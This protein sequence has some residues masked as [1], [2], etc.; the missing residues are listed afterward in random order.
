MSTRT[1]VRRKVSARRDA[2]GSAFSVSAEEIRELSERLGEPQWLLE[3]RLEALSHYEG[4][5]MPTVSDEPWRRTDIRSLPVGEVRFAPAIDTPVD[6]ALLEPLAG[7][8]HGALLTLRP[9]YPATLEGGAGLGEQGVL[10]LDWAEAVREHPSL[11]EKRLSSVVEPVEGKFAAMAAALSDSGVVVYVPPGVEV[12]APLHS[13]L[14]APGGEHAFSSRLLVILD[15]G[16]SLTYTHETA[17]PT[18]AEGYAIH[19]GIVE[20]VVEEGAHLTFIELQNW[21]EHVWNFTHERCRVARDGSLDWIFGAVG[22]RLTKNFT[23]LDLAGQGAEGRMSGFYFADGIQHLD[24]DTQQ[25]HLAPDTRSDLLFKGG[26]VQRSRS[27]WQGMIYVDKVAQRTDGYQANRNLLLSEK[28]RADSIPGL[29]ILADD[30][31]CTHGAT[32][33]QL[34]ED[35][36]FYLMSRGLDRKLAERLV[37]KGFFEEVM[38][39]IPFENV[40]QRFLGMIDDKMG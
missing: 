10:F 12:A 30:V 35:P 29:E 5:P 15:Q 16:A 34:E 23:E 11:L 38:A 13:V 21:G 9:G 14:W 27:V 32:I 26:L 18:A 17:S 39:R 8:K 6:P 2:A 33:G 31:R 3:R 4:V 20:L 1:V 28:A 37:V 40:R 36:I 25:N 7:E 19:S 22:S 24:H